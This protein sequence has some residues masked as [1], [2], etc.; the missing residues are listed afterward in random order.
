MKYHIKAPPQKRWN[1]S[2]GQWEAIPTYN[3]PRPIFG[4]QIKDGEGGTDDR[5]TAI[6]FADMGY[7]V[8]PDPKNGSD[9]DAGAQGPR[10]PFG[11]DGGEHLASRSGDDEARIAELEKELADV[12]APSGLSQLKARAKTKRR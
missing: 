12:R 5:Q 4:V 7:R 9:Q 1:G 11:G 6:E 10:S 2:D 8:E 3:S